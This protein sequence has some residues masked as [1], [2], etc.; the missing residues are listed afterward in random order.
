M[1]ANHDVSNYVP[2]MEGAE[3]NADEVSMILSRRLFKKNVFQVIGNDSAGVLLEG[4]LDGE[5]FSPLTEEAVTGGFVIAEMRLQ[6]VR[7]IRDSTAGAV[8]VLV[9]SEHVD[10]EM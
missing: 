2:L 8:K 1:S 4:S 7:A 10:P 5:N 9:F 6:A 3:D